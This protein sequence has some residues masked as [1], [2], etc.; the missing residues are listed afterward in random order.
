MIK[1]N[2][3]TSD[4]HF[5]S[6]RTLSLS[7]RPFASTD[8]MDKKIIENFNS[9]LNGFTKRPT[10]LHIG[11][12]GDFSKIKEINADI[13]LLMGNYEEKEMK[14]KFG[15]SFFKYRNYLIEQGFVDVYR[16]SMV[17]G[18]SNLESSA[19]LTHIHSGLVC[20]HEPVAVKSSIENINYN[21]P[22]VLFGHIHGRQK[23][24]KFGLDV[25][26]DAHNFNLVSCDDVD[27]YFNAI[28]N[29]YDENVFI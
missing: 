7:K 19:P 2:F 9:Q 28:K 24:K 26:V 12:F 13:Y 1:F 3:F 16:S 23:V 14:E 4:T 18:L 21:H 8:E 5:G 20:V 29:F 22:F 17:L 15:D 25:G 27:F 10:I 6:E 11:D